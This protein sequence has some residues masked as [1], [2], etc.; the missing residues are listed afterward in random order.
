MEAVLDSTWSHCSLGASKPRNADLFDPG[1][2]SE[3]PHPSG[4]H[5]YEWGARRSDTA[6]GVRN[7]RRREDEPS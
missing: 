3:A 6:A 2:Q 4:G 1:R 5:L 7:T